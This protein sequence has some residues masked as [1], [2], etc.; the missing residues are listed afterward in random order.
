MSG[1]GVYEISG[2][3]WSGAGRIRKVEVSADGGKSWA[4]A[5]LPEL[6]SSKG[7][8]RFRL[9]WAWSGQPAVLVS[10]ATD[11]AGAVQPT[12]KAWLAD[13]APGQA[14]HYHALASWGVDASGKV[15][16]VYAS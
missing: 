7:L 12:R 5:Q 9:P 6:N 2:L 11:E 3:A 16:H 13:Y 14:Y 8:T 15:S 1:P 10:R 4:E